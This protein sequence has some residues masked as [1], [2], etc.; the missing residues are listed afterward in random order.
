V[1]RAAHACAWAPR[2]RDGNVSRMLTG[3]LDHAQRYHAQ[4]SDR[5]RQYL[6]GRGID[7]A[8]IERFLIGWSGWRITI[9]IYD[10]EGAVTF[11]KLAKDPADESDSPKMLTTPGSCAELYGWERVRTDAP[12]VVICEGE[13]DRLVLESRGFPAVTSTGGALTF[14]LAW[15]EALRAVPD[16]YVCFDADEAGRIGAERVAR[17]VPHARVVTLPPEVGE[18]GDVTDFFVRLGMSADAFRELLADAA[19]LPPAPVQRRRPQ[20]PAARTEIDELKTSV[21]I[22]DVVAR[23]VDDL[24]VTGSLLTAP[25]PFHEDRRPSFVVYPE[26]QTFHCFGCRAGGDV[27]SFLMKAERLGFSDAMELLRRLAA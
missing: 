13:F 14:R 18:S 25:C 1:P 3:L 27:I 17:L 21:R 22:E 23:Y 24:T 6:N 9:P 11:F 5:I 8:T 7:D 20:S 12:Y 4:L 26:T 15:A 10:R 16:V 2:E 19:Q